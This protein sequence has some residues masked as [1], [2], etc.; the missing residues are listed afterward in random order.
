M[1]SSVTSG[2]AARRARPAHGAVRRPVV[3]LPAPVRWALS[4]LLAVTTTLVLALLALMVIIPLVMHWVPL[5]VLSGSMEPTI[6]VGSQVVV[7]RVESDADVARLRSGQVI[8]FLPDP[9]SPRLVTHRIVTVAV[10]SDGTRTIR[11]KGDANASEDPW[12]LGTTQIRGVVQY[13]LPYVGYVANVLNRDEKARGI[14]LVA[15]GLFAYAAWQ[16]LVAL[17]GRRAPEE[18]P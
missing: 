3:R 16:A 17:R 4:A 7:K 11:T 13:H 18:T 14:Y 12:R 8:T 10:D 6:P 9:G 5:T 2:P 1:A 15:G